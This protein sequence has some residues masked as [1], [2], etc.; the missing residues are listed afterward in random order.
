MKIFDTFNT[1]INGLRSKVTET[2]KGFLLNT[3]YY[4]QENLSPVPFESLSAYSSPYSLNIERVLY[5]R[6]FGWRRAENIIPCIVDNNNVNNGISYIRVFSGYVSGDSKSYLWEIE[7]RNDLTIKLRSIHDAGDLEF[8]QYC[9]QDN[10]YIYYIMRS[11][12]TVYLYRYDKANT[13][14]SNRWSVA[15]DGYGYPNAVFLNEDSNYI[16]IAY[17]LNQNYYFLRHRKSDGNNVVCGAYRGGPSQATANLYASIQSDFVVDL[18]NNVYG[19]YQLNLGNLEQPL[20]LYTVD[21]GANFTTTYSSA[22]EIRHCNI[23]WNTE[24]SQIEYRPSDAQSISHFYRIFEMTDD[25]TTYLCLAVYEKNYS[26][27]QYC[28]VQGIYVFEQTDETNFVFI[29]YNPIYDGNQIGGLLLDQTKNYGIVPLNSAARL[30]KFD[31]TLKEWVPIGD[32]FVSIYSIGFD[33]LRR[34]WYQTLDGSVEVLNFEDPRAVDIK[35]EKAFY[36]FENEEI[37]TY[38]DFSASN[39]GGHGSAGTFTLTMEGSAKFEDSD[40]DT[41]TFAY[42]SGVVRIPIIINGIKPVVIYP[43]YEG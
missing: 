21:T 42:T 13:T 39:Y 16:W 26:S 34:V 5:A 38:I 8:L 22:C 11:N 30:I 20:D 36:I 6:Q 19:I 29:S 24:R 9:T 33:K 7:E 35:F 25:G 10:S 40:S 18:G 4:E 37:S 41:L 23:I 28:K 3:N 14:Q 27:A 15:S 43:T 1:I 17:N 2:R 12:Q 31:T 32:E